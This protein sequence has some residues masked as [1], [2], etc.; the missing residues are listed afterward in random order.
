MRTL[1]ILGAGGHGKVVADCAELIRWDKIH[2]YD[3]AWPEKAKDEHWP[4]L[5]NT[6]GLLER[7]RQYAGVFVAIGDGRRRCERID[8]LHHQGAHVVTLLH[9][10][11]AVS[12]YAVL[13]MGS[14]MVAGAVINAFARTERGCVINTAA[15]VGHDCT[16]GIGVHVA[17][18]ANIAGNVVIEDH[19]WIGIGARIIQGIQVGAGAVIG[20]GATVIDHVPAGVTVV[21]T[22]ARPVG[23]KT[24]QR[25][26]SHWA[27]SARN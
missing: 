7:A 23:R 18:G 10:R 4:V 24:A 21:G 19:A 22:P 15:T 6:Q 20:A 26:I 1:A 17:P 3:D 25:S 14:V 9:P 11:A 12:R 5:G 8:E 13:G 16:L 2:F 27:V